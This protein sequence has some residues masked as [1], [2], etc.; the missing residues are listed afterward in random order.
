LK[1]E[2]NIDRLGEELR[3]RPAAASPRGRARRFRPAAPNDDFYRA[4]DDFYVPLVA[5]APVGRRSRRPNSF[6][7]NCR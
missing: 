3:L 6:C 5:A 4:I 1:D 2:K 7:L